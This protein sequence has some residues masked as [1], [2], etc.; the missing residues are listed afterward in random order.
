V[1]P[2]DLDEDMQIVV[3]YHA[4]EKGRVQVVRDLL[5][6][7]VDPNINN[8]HGIPILLDECSKDRPNLEMI[9]TIIDSG[10][11]VNLRIW[12]RPIICQIISWI[13]SNTNKTLLLE[14]LKKLIKAGADLFAEESWNKINFFDE[15]NNKR[16]MNYITV[17]FMK[18]VMNLIKTESPEQY[19]RYLMLNDMEKYNL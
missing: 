11:N 3:L 6:K 12:Q 18:K 10:A 9:Q 4:L 5:K 19:E 8:I 13:K 16:T 17:G 15:L 7:G 2:M 14:I 1:I